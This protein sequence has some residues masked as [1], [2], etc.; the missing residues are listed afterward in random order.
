MNFSA[1]SIRTP[2]PAILLFILLTIAGLIAFRGIGVQ[3]LPDMDFPMATVT[4]SLPGASPEQLQAEVTRPIEDAIASIGSVRHQT[5]VINDGVSSTLVEFA[6]E[7]NLQDGLSDIRDAVTRIRASLPDD[8]QEPV[9][10]RVNVSSGAALLTYAVSAPGMDEADTSWFVDDVVTKALLTVR[11]VGQVSR[12]GGVVREAR[13]ELDPVRLQAL[14]VTAGEISRQLRRTQQEAPGGSTDLGGLQQTVRTLG[15]VS[16][17]EEL[18]ALSISLQDG[19]RIRLSDVAKVSDGIAERRQLSLLDGK[20]TLSFQIMRARGVDD[21]STARRAR[22]AVAELQQRYPSIGITEIW[23]TADYSESEY[24][25]AMHM[26]IE[27]S[28]LAVLVVWLFLRDWRATFVSAVA[29]PLSIIP[30]FLVI[31]ALGYS[32]NA[33]SLLALTLVI[34]ILVDDAIVEVENIIRHLGMG[35][36]PKQAALEAADEIGLAVI[37]TSL[38]LVAVF[39]PTA[40]VGGLT[41]SLFR[42]FGWTAAAAVLFSLLVARLLTPMMSAYMLKPHFRPETEGPVMRRY[43][44]VAQWCLA[45]PWITLG[46]A[47]AIFIGSLLLISHLPSGYITIV[48]PSTEMVAIEGPPGSTLESTRALAER[49]RVGLAA[50][51]DV[52]AIHTVIGAGLQT[53]NARSDMGSSLVRNA[54][55]TLRLR[56]IQHR[57]Q[58]PEAMYRAM[59]AVL[60]EVPGARISIGRGSPG[61]KMELMF[62]GD[63]PASVMQ[64]TRTIESGLRTLPGF[65]AVTSTASVFRPELVIRPDSERAAQQG[66][67]STAIGEAVRIATAGDYDFNL[68]KLTLPGRQVNVRVLLSPE[69]RRD[70]R[71]VSQLHVE[72][73]NGGVALGNIAAIDIADGPAQIERYDRQRYVKLTVA[74]DGVPIGEALKRAQAL[75]AMQ[76]LPP[77]VRLVMSG[78]LEYMTEMNQGFSLAMLAGVFCVY[79]VMVLLF[80]DFGQPIT[81]LAA[82]PLASAG[83][84]GLLWLFDYALSLAAIIG[85]LMLI[86]IVTKNSILLVDYA[87]MARRDLQMSLNEALLDACRKR[88]RPI[89]MTTVAMAAGMAPIA[90][91]FSGDTG[92]RGPMAIVVIGGLIT[93]TVLSLLVVPVVFEVVDET[94]RR[95]GRLWWRAGR[96]SRGDAHE[97]IAIRNPIP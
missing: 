59:R 58:K 72:G 61:E 56:P 41:G 63:D 60:T 35:K 12:Q 74:L 4:A 90:L 76:K 1:W 96:P 46:C 26:L 85:L 38:T 86:G 5:T 87:I 67:T 50:I 71:M 83:A 9:I 81:V 16:S 17:V 48:D 8:L 24:E 80:H 68:P 84:L 66:I 82:L 18:A 11:G 36:S 97:E 75:P 20:P 88:A 2:T 52:V 79:A 77:G 57:I 62:V 73:V 89:V 23:N 51:P 78:D 65:G 64:A 30:T 14:Q 31:Y 29:L 3:Y 37:A 45:H 33:L 34:G 92:F 47:S 7:Q 55:L 6:F 49:A 70:P 40:V 94:K 54:Q 42:Q 21:V 13:V 44:R 39:L 32:L 25:T 53:G 28:I 15:M 43:L 10:S 93:S 91:G 95:L 69:A 22:A 19:R 27:G